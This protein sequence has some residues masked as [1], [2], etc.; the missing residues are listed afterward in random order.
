MHI[1]GLSEGIEGEVLVYVDV[2]QCGFLK[3]IIFCSNYYI[4]IQITIEAVRIWM[5]TV[6]TDS[7][8]SQL[9]L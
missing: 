9:V 3:I 6:Q 7:V 4:K 2:Q 5:Y 8:I 1:Q